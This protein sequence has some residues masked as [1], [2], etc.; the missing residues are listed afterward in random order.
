[1]KTDKKQFAEWLATRPPAIQDMVSL[2]PP[3]EY[4]IKE[5]A[6]YGVSTPGTTV[7]LVSYSEDGT[8]GVVVMAE[9]KTDEAIEHEKQLGAQHGRT[10]Q[11]IEELH[12]TNIKVMVEPKWLE[13]I[14]NE[15]E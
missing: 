4:K 10:P 6:P 3:G 12:K 5:D 14:T 15:L 13:L 8:V 11:E 1:M 9:N 2:Y 7:N